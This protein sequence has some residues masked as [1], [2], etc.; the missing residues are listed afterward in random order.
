MDSKNHLFNDETIDGMPDG[1]LPMDKKYELTEEDNKDG[2]KELLFDARDV[3]AKALGNLLSEL[4]VEEKYFRH[5]YKMPIGLHNNPEESSEGG[6]KPKAAFYDPGKYGIAIWRYDDDLMDYKEAV[7]DLKDGYDDSE[8]EMKL[9]QSRLAL[10]M[11]HEM[12]H[13]I[14]TMKMNNR[15]LNIGDY[16]GGEG[17]EENMTEVL[18][19]IAVKSDKDGENYLDTAHKFEE[20][21]NNSRLPSLGLFSKIIQRMDKDLLVWF[22]TSAQSGDLLKHNRI[23]DCFGDQYD[24]FLR[25]T[26]FLYEIETNDEGPKSETIEIFGQR[27]KRDEAMVAQR[28]IINETDEIINKKL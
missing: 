15:F 21:A 14:L 2:T 11:T 7:A 26:N 4:G 5:I 9:A 16:L 22:L 6:E 8:E 25:N 27:L 23:K 20:Y 3:A 19:V 18:S 17:L 13:S 12:L 28:I 24:T 10:S 1:W